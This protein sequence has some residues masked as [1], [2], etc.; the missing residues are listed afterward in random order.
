MCTDIDI[1]MHMH[2]HISDDVMHISHHG[3]VLMHAR[4]HAHASSKSGGYT[5]G[6]TH[7]CIDHAHVEAHGITRIPTASI[8]M[9][10]MDWTHG[11]GRWMRVSFCICITYHACSCPYMLLDCVHACMCV[12]ACIPSIHALVATCSPLLPSFPPS[13]PISLGYA[14]IISTVAAF[15]LCF[16]QPQYASVLYLLGQGLDAVDGVVARKFNQCNT[17]TGGTKGRGKGEKGGGKGNEES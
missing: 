13:L 5:H 3:R 10:Y 11:A 4:T 6:C 2:M 15:W 9:P 8:D 1:D 16:T 14:R 17:T 12:H 7:G